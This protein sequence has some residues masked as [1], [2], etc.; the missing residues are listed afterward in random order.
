MHKQCIHKQVILSIGHSYITQFY[1]QNNMHTCC[2]VHTCELAF[3]RTCGRACVC[4]YFRAY[5]LTYVRAYL[6][7]YVS[8][9]VRTCV[10]ACIRACVSVCVCA[11]V[12]ECVRACAWV[13]AHEYTLIHTCKIDMES[14]CVKEKD[15][16]DRT[17]WNTD[18]RNHSGDARWR[19]N[20]SR[21][22]L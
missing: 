3:V 13:R 22:Q 1:S 12:R 16:L 20:P 17:K 15:V 14:F 11:C 19:G 8:A 10:S 9:F 5:V 4:A 18:T 7:V 21:R 6:R 2:Y